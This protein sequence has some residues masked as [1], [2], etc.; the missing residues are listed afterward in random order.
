MKNLILF[1]GVAAVGNTVYHIA[2]KSLNPNANPMLLLAA[3]YAAA[4]VLTL[5]L[6]PLFGKASWG[7]VPAMAA[8]WRIWLTAL[9]VLLI[10]LGFV[11]AYQ[12][13]GSV[14]WSGIA[15]NGMAALLLLPLGLLLFGEQ[16]SWT[17]AA[18]MLMTLGGL[19]CLTKK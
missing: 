19:Y 4:C 17:K 5:L 16:F 2:V 15:V 12:S 14:Q 9:G 10:E 8:D 1:L 3:V 13:G 6:M 11:L 7:E 18:G